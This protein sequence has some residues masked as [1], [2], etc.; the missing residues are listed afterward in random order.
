MRDMEEGIRKAIKQYEEDE[1]RINNSV[2][3]E[4][5]K[6]LIEYGYVQCSLQIGYDIVSKGDSFMVGLQEL[7][8]QNDKFEMAEKK[9]R[10]KIKQLELATK[11]ELGE[12]AKRQLNWVLSLLN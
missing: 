8:L 9:I 6:G 7:V 2:L 5:E 4:K 12:H 3:S 1:I 11:T 10:E